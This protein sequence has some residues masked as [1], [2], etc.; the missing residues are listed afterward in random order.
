MKRRL[1]T[2]ASPKR[3]FDKYYVPAL[4]KG[5]D[6]LEALAFAP[7]PQSLSELARALKRTSSEL[8]R[9][10]SALEKRRYIERDP[11]SSKYSLTLRLYELAHTHS[12]VEKLLRA[13]ALPMR[14][15]ATRLKESCHISTLTAGRLIVLAEAESPTVYRFSV[16]VGSR[17]S[18]VNTAS[19][20][21]L[22]SCMSDE[23]FQ[24]WRRYSSDYQRL[25]L[26]ARAKLRATLRHIR[27]SAIS[28]AHNEPVI[29]V[30]SYA[31][32]LGN[33]DT[34]LRAALAVASLDMRNKKENPQLILKAL[35]ATAA[36]INRSLGLRMD[37]KVV[38]GGP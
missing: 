35:V 1:S 9:M 34:D 24:D 31:V 4:E 26:P 22:L 37:S 12:P 6:V 10:L 32:L 20:R 3:N 8:F 13:A 2:T 29:G 16:E 11:V 27:R 28:T 18:A 25:S 21:L 15:L 17:F 23:E 5:L 33:P 30:R 14:A 38:P 7:V 36:E 19:G